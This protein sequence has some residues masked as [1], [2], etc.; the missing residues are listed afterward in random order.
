MTNWEYLM[1]TPSLAAKLLAN[2]YEHGCNM[3]GLWMLWLPFGIRAVRRLPRAQGVAGEG[4]VSDRD[5][6][7]CSR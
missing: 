4:D 2:V 6:V 7:R 3:G 5:V 1:G